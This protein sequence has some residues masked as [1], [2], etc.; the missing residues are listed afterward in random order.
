MTVDTDI[1]LYDSDVVKMGRVMVA[2]GKCV[3][4]SVNLEAFRRRIVD[5]FA[6]IG[7]VAVVM[8][9]QQDNGGGEALYSPIITITGRLNPIVVE[10]DHEQQRHEIAANLLED[11]DSPAA[12]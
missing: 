3:G 12:T 10:F 5:E 11:P 8:M 1:E 9:G 2:L 6:E 4:S 7:L